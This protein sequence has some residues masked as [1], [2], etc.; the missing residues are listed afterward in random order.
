MSLASLLIHFCQIQEDVGAVVDAYGHTTEDWQP[1]TGLEDFPCRLK[2]STG[3]EILVGAEVVVAD[4]KLFLDEET[5]D[6]TAVLVTEQNRAYVWVKDASGAWVGV[7]YEIL[8]VNHIQNGVD[9][10]HKECY[11]RTVR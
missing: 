5:P 3:R 7:T 2:T 1:V 8:L 4:Y 9:G 10:H 6:G 11:L